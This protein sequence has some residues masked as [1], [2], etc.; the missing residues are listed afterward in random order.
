MVFDQVIKDIHLS[1]Q[2]ISYSLHHENSQVSRVQVLQVSTRYYSLSL[3]KYFSGSSPKES[4]PNLLRRG[5][6]ETRRVNQW[7]ITALPYS[8][9]NCEFLFCICCTIQNVNNCLLRFLAR[10]VAQRQVYWSLVHRLLF[11]PKKSSF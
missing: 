8:W 10:I 4:N 2:K 3:N 1:V 5:D 11:I 9:M 7:Y 6:V